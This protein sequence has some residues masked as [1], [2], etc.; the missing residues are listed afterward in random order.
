MCSEA[1]STPCRI[2]ITILMTPAAPAAICACPMLDL[3]DPSHSGH[4]LVPLLPVR[5]QQR[6]R[7]DRVTQSGPRA[8]RLDRVHLGG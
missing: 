4:P 5:G 3:M 1:G 8:M 6:L 7:L 2:A